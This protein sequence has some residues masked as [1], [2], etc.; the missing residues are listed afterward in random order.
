MI[1]VFDVWLVAII[2]FF[3]VML[4]YPMDAPRSA[5][6]VAAHVPHPARHFAFHLYAF[7]F[8]FCLYLFSFWFISLAA[9]LLEYLS[10]DS[11]C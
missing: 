6:W 8:K 1:D 3:P 10:R 2:M 5:V 11:S 7:L 9:V 4:C